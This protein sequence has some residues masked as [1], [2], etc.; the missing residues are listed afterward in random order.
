ML[1]QRDGKVIVLIVEDEPLLRMAAID[2]VEDAGFEAMEAAD[3]DQA[4][5]ILE[6]RTDIHIVFTD[7]DMPGSIDGLKLAE[8]VRG[9]WPPIHIIVTSGHRKVDMRDLPDGSVFFPKPYREAALVTELNRMA[10]QG[11]R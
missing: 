2:I 9:R 5:L 6:A 7:V 8:A 11:A 1:A 3:A 10:A 4:I